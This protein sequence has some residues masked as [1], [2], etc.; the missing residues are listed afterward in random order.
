MRIDGLVTN[1]IHGNIRIRPAR[2]AA[3][4][5]LR[6]FLLDSRDSICHRGQV[7]DWASCRAAIAVRA[8]SGYKVGV[9][10]GFFRLH[11]QRSDRDA[12]A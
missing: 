11:M 2:K 9:I 5:Q 12:H 10:R 4:S 7:C 3:A 6:Q 8:E 1:G